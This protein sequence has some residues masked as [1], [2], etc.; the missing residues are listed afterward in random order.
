MSYKSQQQ[1]PKR[2]L[3]SWPFSRISW[4]GRWSPKN[5]K[6]VLIYLK[7]KK[8]PKQYLYMLDAIPDPNQLG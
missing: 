8:L 2:Q 3:F 6:K 7:N 1:K 5:L 4:V